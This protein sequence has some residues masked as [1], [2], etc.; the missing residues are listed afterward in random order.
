MYTTH[1]NRPVPPRHTSISNK[2]LNPDLT[3]MLSKIIPN[4]DINEIPA[5]IQE[6]KAKLSKARQRHSDL[7]VMLSII[8]KV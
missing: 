5:T 2:E 1:L 6:E 4:N 3:T 7:Y 8:E